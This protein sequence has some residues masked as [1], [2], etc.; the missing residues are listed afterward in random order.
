M[1]FTRYQAADAFLARA[2]ARLE[3]REATNNLIVSIAVR[4]KEHPDRIK[5]PPYLATVE[6]G[7]ALVAA[8]VMTPPH[9]VI[10]HG[11]EGS[12]DPA[13]LRLIVDDL[14]AGDWTPPGVTGPAEVARAFGEVWKTA[15][16]G[17]VRLNMH[18]RIYDLHQVVYPLGVPGVLRA[19]TEADLDFLPRWIYEFNRDAGLDITVEAA[20][21]TAE[22]RVGDRDIFLWE[23]SRGQPASM[24]AKTRHSTHGMIVSL[25]YTP[26]DFRRRGYAGA[27]VA[28]LS[29]QLLDA[30]WEWCALFT[31]LANPT[32]N[33]VYQK[34]GYRPVCDFD[35][36]VFE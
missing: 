36:Y 10:I 28:A 15:R 16:G 27:C 6:D 19:A 17:Q 11:P 21:E 8:A 29:Q 3:R 32:S 4:L 2:Q 9:R 22:V 34:I 24:A 33:S 18:L 12:A 7:D 5:T 20:Q 30:G 25:V 31:N 14:I 35:E 13:P 1:L 26:P 23:A